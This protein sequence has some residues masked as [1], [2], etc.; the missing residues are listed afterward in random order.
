MLLHKEKKWPLEK[1]FTGIELFFFFK[2]LFDSE[3]EQG[4]WQAEG[5]REASSQLSQEPIVGLNP[6]T[7]GSWPEPNADAL[8]TEPPR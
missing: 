7:L 4:E 8:P 6:R 3:Y 2:I 1:I 5:E